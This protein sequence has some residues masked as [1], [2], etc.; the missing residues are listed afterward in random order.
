MNIFFPHAVQKLFFAHIG[1]YNFTFGL[2]KIHI[3]GDQLNMTMCFWYLVKS[4][5]S[6][7]QCMRVVMYTGQFTDMFIWSGCI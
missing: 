2:K 3:K 1:N 5:L 6:N 7:V 4:D